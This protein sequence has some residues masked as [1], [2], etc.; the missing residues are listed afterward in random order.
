MSIKDKI[1][2]QINSKSFNPRDYSPDQ[3]SVIDSMLQQGVI[4]GPRMKDIVT[5]FEGT[6]QQ[7]SKEKEFAK[8]PLGYALQ[9]KSIF[10]GELTGLI[11][12]RAGSELIGDLTGSLLPYIRNNKALVQSLSMPKAAQ[13]K[14]FAK[15]AIGLANQLEKIPRIGKFF[16][17]TKPLLYRMGKSVDSVTSARMKPLLATEAQS[18]AGGAIGAGAGTVGYDL[19]NQTVGK[20]LAVAINNDLADM[21]EQE[22]KTDTVASA[23]EA[24]KN[25]LMWGAAGTAMMPILGILGKGG[26]RLFGL[27]GDKARELSEYAQKKGLPLPLLATMSKEEKG[28]ILANLGRT[29]FKTIGLFPFIA[30]TGEKAIAAA[31][32]AGTTAFLDD[33]LNIAPITK[34]SM[35]GVG[36]LNAFRE[37]F[38]KYGELISDGYKAFDAKVADVGNPAIVQLNKTQEFAQQIAND[39]GQEIP[40]IGKY[41]GMIQRGY[42]DELATGAERLAD[43][44]LDKTLIGDL[45]DRADPLVQLFANLAIRQNQPMTIKEYVGLQKIATKAYQQT[46]LK[47]P[48][49]MVLGLKESLDNDFAQSIPLLTKDDMLKD[50]ALKAEYDATVQVSGQKAA[51]NLLDLRYKAAQ[52]LN[53]EL[54]LANTQFARLLRPFEYSAVAQAVKAGDRSLFTNKQLLGISGKESIPADLMFEAIEKSTFRQGSPIAV[55]QLKVLYGQ[56][57]GGKEMF[58]RAFSRY[59]YDSYLG[60]FSEKGISDASVF[61]YIKKQMNDSPRSKMISDVL[62]RGGMEDLDAAYGTT[63][64]D[65][66]SGA[67]DEAIDITFGKGDFAEFNADAFARNLGFTGPKALQRR[68]MLKEAYGGGEKGAKALKDLDDF[69]KY[70]KAISEVPISEPSA[71]LQRR[72]TLGGFGSALGGVVMGGSLFAANPLAP[73]IMLAAGL[74]MGSVLTNPTS[75]RYM[76]DA[77]GP[78]ER[79]KAAKG[80]VGLKKTR[81]IPTTYG[82]TESRAFARFMN[83]LHEE[84]N[85]IPKVDP[86]NINPEEIINRLQGVSTKIPKRGFNY[87]KLPDNEKKRMFPERELA[88]KIPTELLAEA[89]QFGKGYEMGQDA[90]IKALNV[91]YGIEPEEGEQ[92]QQAAIPGAEGIPTLQAPTVNTPEA[93]QVRAQKYSKLFPFDVTGQGIAE[94]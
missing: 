60:A 82:E 65:I 6:A 37:N 16:K 59:M 35:L 12:T 46:N 69:I 39:F 33:V 42:R 71:F 30:P 8:D 13:S 44:A 70:A 11:P 34:T 10:Q 14:Q 77:L 3:L 58:N 62:Q 78:E 52:S 76:M 7:I 45:S 72:I 2:E 43:E 38:Q 19:V 91:D 23:V 87:D 26:R 48:R 73:V 93:P 55:K 18:L 41:T 21:P 90:D 31:E 28:A 86:K 85:D 56:D 63:V 92:Q 5:E 68:E 20:D 79:L 49:E 27:K 25:S 4:Q 80:M 81:G 66:T 1:Q 84:D 29:Y 53:D 67:G 32:R 50:A 88:D 61:N 24:M 94:S 74:K 40:L 36:S 54:K 51:D 15:A 47:L 64:K 83:Y 75:I 9:D 57:A 22:V 89:D 17:F